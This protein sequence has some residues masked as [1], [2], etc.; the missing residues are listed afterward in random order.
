MTLQITSAA[1]ADVFRLSGIAAS[2]SALAGSSLARRVINRYTVLR[3][4]KTE[5]S[6]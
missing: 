6:R 1:K 3:K 5:A 4:G 2:P